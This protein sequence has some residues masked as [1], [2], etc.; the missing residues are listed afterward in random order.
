MFHSNMKPSKKWQQNGIKEV[1]GMN[2]L[3]RM[4]TYAIQRRL[5]TMK[6]VCCC[7]DIISPLET[8]IMLIYVRHYTKGM[9]NI[10][11]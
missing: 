2:K 1:G 8:Y 10:Y 4:I 3:M 6:L 5:V 11:Q 7:T 9:P